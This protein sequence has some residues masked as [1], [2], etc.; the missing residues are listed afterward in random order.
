[1][2]STAHGDGVERL[3]RGRSPQHPHTP[4]R[5]R[6]LS[7]TASFDLEREGGQRAVGL[8][9][10]AHTVASLRMLAADKGDGSPYAHVPEDEITGSKS[11][12]RTVREPNELERSVFGAL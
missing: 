11:R 3:R 12:C 2:H 8:C 5:R 7:S 6:G 4:P 1:M 9:Q 10:G